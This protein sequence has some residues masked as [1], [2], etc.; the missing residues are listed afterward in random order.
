MVNHSFRPFVRRYRYK[1]MKNVLSQLLIILSLMEE[2]VFL[3]TQSSPPL[4]NP[5][6]C[7]PW[8][9]WAIA[10]GPTGSSLHGILQA[11]ILEWVAISSSKNWGERIIKSAVIGVFNKHR[12]VTEVTSNSSNGE[13]KVAQLCPT[14]CNPV[15][16]IV[17]GILQ[18]RILQYVPFSR[19]FPNPEIKPRSPTL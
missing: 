5:M 9:P 12:E 11:S 1:K 8:N 7:S 17:H 19:E 13:V 2:C 3:V 10:M 16:Y 4:C 15:N 18:A 14:V 6:D